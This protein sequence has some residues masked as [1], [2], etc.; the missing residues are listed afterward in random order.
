MGFSRQ[1]Y[2][3]GL[4]F[5]SPVDHVLSEFSTMTWIMGLPDSLVGKE[6]SCN[7]GDPGSIPGSGRFTGEGLGYPFK[8]SWVSLVAQLVKN[9]PA[10]CLLR[11][12]G[13]TW[14]RS[15]GGKIPWRRKRLS[16]RGIPRILEWVAYLFSTR[17][18]RPR[19]RT[20]VSCIAGRF[21]TNW[22][23][24]EAHSYLYLIEF[25]VTLL[26]SLETPLVFHIVQTSI[27]GSSADGVPTLGDHMLQPALC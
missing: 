23:I 3:S 18:S 16:H 27:R 13:E 5:P 6:S 21:F 25:W 2:W 7:A 17:L 11:N 8:C 9:L 26:L 19:N 10:I 24:K 4:S 22:A 14:V 1:E 15:L 20:R 12:L